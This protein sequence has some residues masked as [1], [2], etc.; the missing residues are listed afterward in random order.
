MGRLETIDQRCD[1]LKRWC[2][3]ALH[4]AGQP[5]GEWLM[6]ELQRLDA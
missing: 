4:H 2:E 1:L 5:M 3:D 6:R